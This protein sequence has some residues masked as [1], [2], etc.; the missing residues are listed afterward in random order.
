MDG[1][2]D[3][4]IYLKNGQSRVTFTS[5]FARTQKLAISLE[6]IIS[7]NACAKT[8]TNGFLELRYQQTDSNGCLKFTTGLSGIGYQYLFGAHVD[9]LFSE[10]SQGITKAVD[11]Y[12]KNKKIKEDDPLS[13]LKTRYAKG[14][15][16]RATY[17]QIK[18]DLED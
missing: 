14:E 7:A 16:D 17:E 4:S 5:S 8:G 9:P 1:K 3:L 6:D 15:I 10:W 12:R 11:S 2:L 13:V 18:K